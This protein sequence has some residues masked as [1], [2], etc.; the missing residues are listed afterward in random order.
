MIK[1][2]AAT[3]EGP[4]LERT[5][6]TITRE[7]IFEKIVDQIVD[8]IRRNKYRPGD[9]IPSQREL[10]QVLKV[11]R[12][13]VRE[14]MTVLEK[15]GLLEVRAGART[16][17]RRAPGPDQEALDFAGLMSKADLTQ[18]LELRTMLEGE[19]AAAAADKATHEELVRV[20]EAVEAM[21]R[22]VAAGRLDAD[23][24]Y[25]FHVQVT[26]ACH[27]PVIFKFWN[28]LSD[29][30]SREILHCRLQSLARGQTGLA[31]AE[32]REV[33]EALRT[34]DAEG[35]RRAMRRH[36]MNVKARYGV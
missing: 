24:D 22:A 20:A 2:A 15:A 1:T 9:A 30:I 28:A 14:A 12:T 29:L 4:D 25:T 11:S 35:A 36:L 7:R 23:E 13:A 16:I 5:F 10:A 3:R 32:H 31:A 26:L 34:R 19:V 8:L 18:L 33:F 21:E 6:T 17:V 27:N